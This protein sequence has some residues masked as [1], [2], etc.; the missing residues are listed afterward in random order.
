M[1]L[2]YWPARYLLLASP[3]LAGRVLQAFLLAFVLPGQRYWAVWRRSWQLRERNRRMM[4]ERG[5]DAWFIVRPAAA[6]FHELRA[7]RR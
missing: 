3:L 1:A 5:L 2:R 6:A 4:E 7:G